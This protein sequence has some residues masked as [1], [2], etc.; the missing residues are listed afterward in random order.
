MRHKIIEETID[1]MKL[2]HAD[3]FLYDGLLMEVGTSPTD[4]DEHITTKEL[5]YLVTELSA[6]REL[7][8]PTMK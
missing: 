4:T 7:K 1:A 3:G 5:Q 2:T 8:A 6:F